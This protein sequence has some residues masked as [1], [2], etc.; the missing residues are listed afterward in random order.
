MIDI[1]HIV[2]T[3]SHFTLT[4]SAINFWYGID[5]LV[6]IQ[7]L[8]LFFVIIGFSNYLFI[9][10]HNLLLP[11]IGDD[12]NLGKRIKKRKSIKINNLL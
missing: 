4:G 8:H 9:I 10:Y 12:K 2:L 1:S 3:Y 7:V 11:V 6:N 5:L